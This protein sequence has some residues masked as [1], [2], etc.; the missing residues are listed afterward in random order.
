MNMK[1]KNTEQAILEAAER[2]FLEKGFEAS[3]TTQ[4]ASRAG[5]THAMLH[6]YHGTK[7]KLFNMV[8]DKKIRLLKESLS[9]LVQNSELP[10]L[11]RIKMGIESH[12]DFIAANPE[13]PRFVI[14]ELIY[15]PKRREMIESVIKRVARQLLGQ[16]Q[17]EIDREV[18]RGVICPIDATVLLLDIASLNIFLF[19]V[20]PI[21]RLFIIP[22]GMS[23]KD[24]L[25]M[26]KKEN[27]EMIMRRLVNSSF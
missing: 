23:E 13:L 26:R 1:D 10:L 14:N 16:L 21:L 6:Y 18:R 5:V 19:A 15:K 25:E 4:I 12:F 27:V 11:E 7:E 8:F 2:E 22:S 20:F 17:Q 24:F 9:I 3:K